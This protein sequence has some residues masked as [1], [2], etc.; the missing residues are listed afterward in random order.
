MTKKKREI[1]DKGFEIILICL[2]AE[3]EGKRL[4][5][6]Q[7]WCGVPVSYAI[8]LVGWISFEL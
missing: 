6:C 2:S 4:F 7:Y 3:F 1:I 8:D 5:N